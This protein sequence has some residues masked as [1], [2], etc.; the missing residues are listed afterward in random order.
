[1]EKISVTDKKQRLAVLLQKKQARIQTLMLKPELTKKELSFIAEE[2]ALIHLV[3]EII[4]TL[5]GEDARVLPNAVELEEAVLGAIMLERN[6]LPA[7]QSYLKVE[8]FYSPVHAVIYKSIL[9]LVARSAPVDMRTVV[10]QLRKDGKIEFVGG[11]SMIAEITSK[12]SSA[13]NCEYHA[14]VVIEFWLKRELIS[15]GGALINESYDE[16][17]D[18]FDLLDA[19]ETELVKMV[20]GTEL[21]AKRWGGS[22]FKE[23]NQ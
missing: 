13:A 8:H 15:L 19:T 2:G 17:V 18:V 5:E 23:S 10:L 16:M 20:Q 4:E 22:Q 3:R 21:A 1:M 11:A 9:N 7:V 6:V 14:H 12:V